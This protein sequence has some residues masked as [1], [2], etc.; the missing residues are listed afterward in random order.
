VRVRH[1]AE[2]DEVTATK[3]Q[4]AKAEQIAM[5]AR[6]IELAILR[7]IPRLDASEVASY[8]LADGRKMIAGLAARY[9]A[10]AR[11]RPAAAA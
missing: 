8:G 3:D 7:L 9:E 6:Q 4:S 2:G 1:H 11:Q 10:M 5:N